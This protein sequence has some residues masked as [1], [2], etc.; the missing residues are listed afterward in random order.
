[1][2]CLEKIVTSANDGGMIGGGAGLE[3]HE[4][5][6]PG[7]IGVARS[8]ICLR[9]AAIVMLRGKDGGESALF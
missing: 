5:S 3:Q 9:P 6:L 2:L 1:M 7:R 8:D 4:Q